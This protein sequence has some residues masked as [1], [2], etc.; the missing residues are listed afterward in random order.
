[1]RDPMQ[2]GHPVDTYVA[3]FGAVAELERRLGPGSGPTPAPSVSSDMLREHLDRGL[4][5]FSA[6]PPPVPPAEF[7]QRLAAYG[8]LLIRHRPA[9]Q[10]ELRRQ[11]A[12]L[13]RLAPAEQAALVAILIAGDTERLHPFATD[14]EIRPERLYFLGELALRPFLIPYAAVLTRLVDLRGYRGACCPLCGRSPIYGRIDPDNIKHLHCATCGTTWRTARVGCTIC[15]NA[16]PTQTGFFTVGDNPERRV[17]YCRACGQYLKVIDQRKRVW[18]VDW[19][20]EDAATAF[21]DQ[22]AAGEGLR[23]GGVPSP[24]A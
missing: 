7:V 14:R 24:V 8:E 18:E 5:L 20:A 16:D 9:L 21:L 1:M 15:G 23:R 6:V 3:F 10:A 22:L 12:V 4:P 17:E 11:A 13:G 19:L 2:G